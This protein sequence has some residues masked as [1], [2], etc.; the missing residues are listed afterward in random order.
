[1]RVL[2][3]ITKFPCVSNCNCVFT[4]VMYGFFSSEKLKILVYLLVLFYFKTQDII[5]YKICFYSSSI[6]ITASKALSV[7][8]FIKL[9]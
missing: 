3:S 8:L 5:F 6:P 4:R 9:C 1:M 7:S 2:P